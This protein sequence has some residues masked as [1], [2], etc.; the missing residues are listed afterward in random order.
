MKSINRKK[1]SIKLKSVFKKLLT[2][3]ERNSRIIPQSHHENKCLIPQG[4]NSH[5]WVNC[6]NAAKVH[7]KLY[8]NIKSKKQND[9]CDVRFKQYS[10]K[11]S[12]F[13]LTNSQRKM[14]CKIAAAIHKKHATLATKKDKLLRKK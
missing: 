14:T 11:Q 6:K 1:R 3:P 13:R 7:T 9:I 2:R 12:P 8:K 5:T 4:R 10:A